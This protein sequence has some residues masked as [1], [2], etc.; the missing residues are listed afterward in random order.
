MCHRWGQRTIAM[1]AAIWHDNKAGRPVTRSL[2]ACD[3]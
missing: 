2:I 1:A 3:H